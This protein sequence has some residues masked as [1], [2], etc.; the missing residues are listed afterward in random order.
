V[1]SQFDNI[2]FPLDND[3]KDMIET[4]YNN[5]VLEIVGNSNAR[6]GPEDK[7]IIVLMILDEIN[8]N[9]G[10]GIHKKSFKKLKYVKKL[11]NKS[12]KY[13]RKYK[14]GNRTN[15]RRR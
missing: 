13:R 5:K 12:N 11:K 9:V 6:I 1:L 8:P 14:R 2:T 15:K 3:D 7:H 10:E 4:I